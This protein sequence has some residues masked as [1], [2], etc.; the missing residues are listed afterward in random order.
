[1]RIKMNKMKAV[2]ILSLFV[3]VFFSC[4]IKN[5]KFFTSTD[6]IEIK[7]CVIPDSAM[8]GDTVQINAKSQQPNG[9]WYNLNFV[10]SKNNDTTYRIKA[11]GSFSNQGR[12]C[13]A[14]LVNKDTIL[15]FIPLK[16]GK[17]LFYISQPTFATI[18][19]LVVK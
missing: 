12:V 16:R 19:T 5:D 7:Q 6:V 1:M 4:S 14:I 3:V 2:F 8:L 13:P 18:D 17:T 9:C 11:F 10:L 15:R